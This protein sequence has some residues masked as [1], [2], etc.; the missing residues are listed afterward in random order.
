MRASEIANFLQVEL[1]GTDCEISAPCSLEN[2]QAHQL[3]FLH[4]PDDDAVRKINV[5][6]HVMALVTESIDAGIQ[7]THVLVQNARLAF[8]KV[9]NRYFSPESAQPR[10]ADTAIVGRNVVLGKG[11]S[12]GEYSVIED[13]VQIG[14]RT[15]IRHHVIIAAGTVIG[16]DCLIMSHCVIGEEGFGF[17]HDETDTPIR[18]PHIGR[19]EI[20]NCVEIGNFNAIPRASLGKTSVGDYTKTGDFVQVPHNARVG[21]CCL[22]AAYAKVGSGATIEDHVFLGV[23][24]S[25]RENVRVGAWALIGQGSV[26]LEDVAPRAVVAGVPARYLRDRR[27]EGGF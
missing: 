9:V 2:I 18:F 17:I 19:T 22:L 15:R 8:A 7:G 11:I 23:R 21:A 3:V 1:R 26:V 12:I 5:T 24:S 4:R 16:A 6:P 13:N 14:D 10:I 20:G 25:T 27:K